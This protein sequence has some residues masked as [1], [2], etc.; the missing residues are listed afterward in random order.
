VSKSKN[1]PHRPPIGQDADRALEVVEKQSETSWAMFQAIANQ[2]ERGFEKTKPA[3]L[4]VTRTDLKALAAVTLDDVLVEV[5][6]NNRVCPLPTVWLRLVA[7]LPNK[8]AHL[9][10]VPATREEWSRTPALQKRSRL[11][12]H[13]EWA[14]TQGV[15]G[16]VYEILRA[17]PEAKWHHMGE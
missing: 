15:L 2:Q 13:V 5:R 11:R 9:P 12:E 17:L 14:S 10:T 4:N 6:R 1:I 3:S 7:V 16:Q 8:P